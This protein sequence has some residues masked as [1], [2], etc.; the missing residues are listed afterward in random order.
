MDSFGSI[1]GNI[2]QEHGISAS[3]AARRLGMR[4]K[5]SLMRILKDQT[6]YATVRTF[7]EQLLAGGELNLSD[8]EQRRLQGALEVMRV[9]AEVYNTNCALQHL[10]QLRKQDVESVP[11]K[12]LPGINDFS[13]LCRLYAD[14]EELE[15]TLMGLCDVRLFHSL[16]QMCSRMPAARQPQITHYIYSIDDTLATIRSVCAI[17]PVIFH[18]NYAF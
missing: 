15:I 5:T 2:L 8:C 18:R 9:G 17:F 3:E 6:G 10:L 12:G 16:Q 1:L 7:W 14:A 13:D 11:V 4:S